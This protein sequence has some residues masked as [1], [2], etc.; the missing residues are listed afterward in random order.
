MKKSQFLKL[1]FAAV[2]AI[3]ICMPGFS[4]NL[5]GKELVKNGEGARNKWMMQVYWATLYVPADLKGAGDTQIID[6]DQ[7]M[8]MDILVTSG[9][10]SKDKFVGAIVEGLKMQLKQVML[11]QINR[12]M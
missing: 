7:P 3:A 6:A 5:G 8:I 4:Y 12:I 1:S 11:Q 9:M 2:L 10:V